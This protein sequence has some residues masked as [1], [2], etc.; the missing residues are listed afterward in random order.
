[1]VANSHQQ[2]R[3]PSV[4]PDVRVHSLKEAADWI[5]RSPFHEGALAK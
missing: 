5:L 2:S 3:D 1:M 4:L